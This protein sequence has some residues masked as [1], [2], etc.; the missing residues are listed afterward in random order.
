M[1]QRSL[2]TLVGT[3][4]HTLKQDRLKK[5]AMSALR[6]IAAF[7]FFPLTLSAQPPSDSIQRYQ[8]QLKANP[9]DSLAHYQLAEAFVLQKNYQSAANEFREA[10]NGNLDPRW[11]EVWS[12]LGLAKVFDASGQ[13]ER[14]SNEL[15]LA[16]R[17]GDNTG[18][19]QDIASSRLNEENPD[20]ILQTPPAAFRRR[21][22]PTGPVPIQ[23]TEPEYSEEARAAGLEGTVFVTTGIG[24]DGTPFDSAVTYGLGLG[25]DEKAIEA[26]KQWRFPPP[27]P[28]LVPTATVAVDFLLPSKLSR[29]HLVGASCETPQGA[30]RPVFL[31]EPYPLGAGISNK[32]MDQGA[33]IAVI[34]RAATVTLRFDVDEH[35]IP[36]NLKALAASAPVWENE[37]IALVLDW[38]FTPGAKDGKPVPVR[39]TLDLVWGEKVW[40]PA[41]LAEL[42]EKLSTVVIALSQ[43]AATAVS[44]TASAP[45]IIESD[46]PRWPYSVVVSAF[47]GQDGVPSNVSLIRSLTPQ[48]DS[49]A[50]ETVRR[51]RFEPALVNGT[52]VV[53]QAIIEVDFT[54]NR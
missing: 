27:A 35:G 20:E 13:Q 4:W 45:Y 29:W 30:S 12:H 51:W 50:L 9:R 23:Q 10:L 38:R 22:T 46:K 49:Q 1:D 8:N 33:V 18:G 44:A 21:L 28:P 7:C 47:I 14:G 39:C 36:A 26:V 48:Y 53:L 40:T 52:P 2:G 16:L 19:A 5:T 11:T 54:R 3:E 31:T 15:R 32:A 43:R 25:L 42:R 17:T 41:T 34:R 37:A 6:L 24:A